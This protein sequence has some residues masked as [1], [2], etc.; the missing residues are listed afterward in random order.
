M[1]TLLFT[2]IQTIFLRSHNAIAKVIH[3]DLH[4]NW[5]AEKV[6]EN[7]KKINT[8]AFQKFFYEDWLK[9]L[10]GEKVHSKN[11]PDKKANEFTDYD[12]DVNMNFN[13]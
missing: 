7:A 2:G 1:I 9:T 11:F 10:L 5:I 6:Y 12:D 3:E 8:A 4:P 13:P